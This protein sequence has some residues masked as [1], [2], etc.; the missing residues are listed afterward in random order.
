MMRILNY[1]LNP[2]FV[3]K[4]WI[5][6]YY[7][8]IY[9]ENRQDIDCF[10]M[11][12]L[13]EFK[14]FYNFIN[15]NVDV[16]DIATNCMNLKQVRDALNGFNDTFVH[17]NYIPKV[18][19]PKDHLTYEIFTWLTLGLALLILTLTLIYCLISNKMQ[20]KKL[21]KEQDIIS[22]EIIASFNSNNSELIT[23]KKD[24]QI[25]NLN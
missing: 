14:I 13:I 22:S 23:Q 8:S 17:K 19:S 24:L 18:I 5:Y 21:K 2:N 6:D 7:D 4:H 20:A 15:D 9:I 10:K 11:L 3:Y 25:E 12:F 1:S 16:N